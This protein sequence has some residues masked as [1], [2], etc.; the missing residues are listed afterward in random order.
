VTIEPVPVDLPGPGP[1][2]FEVHHALHGPGAPTAYTIVFRLLGP[3][4]S[5]LDRE[6]LARVDATSAGVLPVTLRSG[7]RIFTAVEIADPALGCTRRLG[8]RRWEAP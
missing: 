3:W 1:R 4:T 2:T 7:E 6:D 8:A 5:E